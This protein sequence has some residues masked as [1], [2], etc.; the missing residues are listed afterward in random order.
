MFTINERVVMKKIVD[1]VR[2]DNKSFYFFLRYNNVLVFSDN[3]V[4][5]LLSVDNVGFFYL[6]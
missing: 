4:R 1:Y 6:K 3:Y 2:L 5:C